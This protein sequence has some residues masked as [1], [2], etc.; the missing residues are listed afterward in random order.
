VILRKPYA[1]LIK[2]FKKIHFIM[3][4][5]MAYIAYSSNNILKFF[6]QLIKTGTFTRFTFSLSSTYIN[7]YLI[8]STILVIGI[9]IVIYILMRQKKK[10]ILFYIIMIGYYAVLIG[11]FLYMYNTFERLEITTIS[12]RGL[13]IIRDITTIVSFTQYGLLVLVAVRAFG[14]NI[15]KFNFGEDLVE[16]E[17]DVKDNEEFELLVGIDRDKIGQRLRKG[18][19]ELR[20]FVIENFFILMVILITTVVVTAVTLVLNFKI[21]NK[22]YYKGNPFTAGYFVITVDDAYY[23]KTNQKGEEVAPKGKI[24]A[25]VTMTITNNDVL[26]RK[27]NLN[28]I[29]IIV[30]DKIYEPKTNRYNSFVDLGEGYNNQSIKSG[31]T[32]KYLFI[33]EL[34]DVPNLNNAV[35]RYRESLIIKSQE[36]KENYKKIKIEAIN[37]KDVKK[38]GS[39]KLGEDLIFKDSQLNNTILNIDNVE[40]NNRFT[41]DAVYCYYSDCTTFENILSLDYTAMD[42][43]LMKL[44]LNYKKDPNGTL[45]NSNSF[46]QLMYYYGSIRYQVNGKTY[47][48]LIVDKTPKDYNGKSL[49]YQVPKSIN[50]ATKLEIVIRIRDKEYVYILK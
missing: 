49:Y 35:L 14:F 26:S 20:Y 4:L 43:T 9:S 28:D 40:I 47:N 33:F 31:N 30:G 5:L 2:N 36:I 13:R 10:P 21:Y 45:G 15:K 50:S 42:K 37:I 19:R 1:L 18:K 17:I 39:A 32:N 12:P 34:D 16:L 41:Y 23:T 7:I 6:N 25:A 22:I 48:S 11:Y 44:D 46:N 29:N 38:I 24:Y 3:L 8:L 27:I